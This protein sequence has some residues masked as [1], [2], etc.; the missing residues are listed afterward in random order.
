MHT[1]VVKSSSGFL[2][3]SGDESVVPRVVSSS[4]APGSL[5]EMQCKLER[6]IS[7]KLSIP[8]GTKLQPPDFYAMLLL[9]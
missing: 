3:G 6:H 8:A 4:S 5:L 2:C 1:W 9:G 7:V